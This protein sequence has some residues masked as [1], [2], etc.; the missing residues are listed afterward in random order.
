MGHRKHSAPRRGSLAF[1]P[2]SR[3]K[4][5]L[6][7]IRTWASP[8]AKQEAPGIAGLI[9]FKAGM[10]HLITVDDREKTPNFGKPL[11]VPATVLS[12]PAARVYGI[13]AYSVADGES[14]VLK[15]IYDPSFEL[16][17]KKKSK[18]NKEDISKL[19]DLSAEITELK[20]LVAIYPREVG[21]SQKK[22]LLY[23]IP[24]IGSDMVK[25][26]EF[27]SQLLGKS[28]QLHKEL[29]AG[30][31][32]DLAAVTKG[33]GFE[34]PITRFG[35]KRKQHKSRKS[36]RAV[37]VLSPWH[38]HDVMYTVPR[39]GQM[40]FHQR[41]EY[42]HKI[43][44]IGDEKSNPI[45]PPGGFPHF[46]KL[47]GDYIVVKGSV[48]GPARRPVIVRKP[49]RPKGKPVKAPQVVMVSSKGVSS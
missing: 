48:P 22:P 6:P 21:L 3:A 11:F 4:S 28:I 19:K 1:A 5:L 24:I 15:D 29:A 37:G 36:V 33:K 30:Q 23:E 9:A 42:N 27:A 49:V 44:L 13:R 31:H 7:R 10:L 41:I 45:T 43:M 39:A 34:G 47:L 17:A 8:S 46:G 18:E 38:P 35:V 2:R 14:Y 26:I 32:V 16:F 25:K 20:V 12:V 40:G